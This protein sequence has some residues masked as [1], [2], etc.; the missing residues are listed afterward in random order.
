MI[1]SIFYLYFIVNV[2]LF[3]SCYHVR[4]VDIV[5]NSLLKSINHILP[6]IP[7][8][9]NELI[10]NVPIEF[11]DYTTNRWYVKY[12]PIYY[13]D[14][15]PYKVITFCNENNFFSMVEQNEILLRVITAF[16]NIGF[17]NFVVEFATNNKSYQ[18][19]NSMYY[20]LRKSITEALQ[21]DIIGQKDMR[22]ILLHHWYEISNYMSSNYVNALSVLTYASSMP[23]HETPNLVT[24]AINNELRDE[25][26]SG[27]WNCNPIFIEIALDSENLIKNLPVSNITVY[28]ND[29]IPYKVLQICNKYRWNIVEYNNLLITI[30][31]HIS[32]LD[33]FG[34]MTISCPVYVYDSSFEVG[35]VIFVAAGGVNDIRIFA[36]EYREAKRNEEGLHAILLEFCRIISHHMTS[37]DRAIFEY[38]SNENVQYVVQVPS[39]Y[40]L[41]VGSMVKMF[42]TMLSVHENTKIS[43]VDGYLLGNYSKVLDSSQIYN[44]SDANSYV[45]ET[46][47]AFR[48]LLFKFEEDMVPVDSVL[49]SVNHAYMGVPDNIPLRSALSRTAYI[50][51]LFNCSLIPAQVVSRIQKGIKRLKFK[52]EIVEEV[53]HLFQKP[54][55]DGRS[56]RERGRSL[57]VSVRTF[58]AKHEFGEHVFNPNPTL[59][60]TVNSFANNFYNDTAPERYK[61]LISDLVRRYHIRTILIAFD[62]PLLIYPE[63]ES[64]LQQL[65]VERNVEVVL[66]PHHY[67]TDISF[68]LEKAT[69]EMLGL[70]KTDYLLGTRGSTFLDMVYW[71]SECKQVVTHVDG[72]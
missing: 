31:Y 7:S 71:L 5:Q 40:P 18:F 11:F 29:N 45:I 3:E 57:G 30:I 47:H 56:I 41:G 58:T 63:Y 22:F 48:L 52:H 14:N 54:G 4:A 59:L 21:L 9:I 34:A 50:D 19:R 70:S 16:S 65:S 61:T 36:K 13:D 44:A 37:H 42:V 35:T 20:G 25:S 39:Y 23:L 24:N 55:R 8:D 49:F 10:L 6:F 66:F 69:L 68:E 27:K 12:I 32:Q 33:D 62:N 46:L 43:N 64:F 1:V 2:I 17:D 67:R 60:H 53:E 51:H 38:L 15:V 26:L 28:L 72:W